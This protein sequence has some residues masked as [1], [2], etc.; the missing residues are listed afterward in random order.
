MASLWAVQEPTPTGQGPAV[1]DGRAKPRSQWKTQMSL[2]VA[3]PSSLADERA[4]PPHT[5]TPLDSSSSN[6]PAGDQSSGYIRYPFLCPDGQRQKHPSACPRLPPTVTEIVPNLRDVEEASVS[7]KGCSSWP[8]LGHPAV[9]FSLKPQ[10]QPTVSP[11]G[12]ALELYGTLTCLA[13][14]P[15]Q[16][17]HSERT[18]NLLQQVTI[19]CI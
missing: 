17:F 6:S 4:P 3:A 1:G 18:R 2:W 10:W 19:G 7:W 5:H 11:V 14:K 16:K 8:A 9:N 12:G 13:W 15:P